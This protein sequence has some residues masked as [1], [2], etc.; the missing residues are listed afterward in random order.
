VTKLDGI[1]KKIDDKINREFV[2]KK[3][4]NWM[5]EIP[6]KTYDVRIDLD[7]PAGQIIMLN[8]EEGAYVCFHS[9]K[10]KESIIGKGDINRTTH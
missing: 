1:S 9:R 8:R 10:E 3:I 4:R 7:V 5:S 6:H 2:Q